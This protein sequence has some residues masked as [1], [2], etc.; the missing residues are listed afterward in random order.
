MTQ[1]EGVTKEEVTQFGAKVSI[2]ICSLNHLNASK[3]PQKML[4]HIC[5]DSLH[6]FSFLS[7]E[8]HE[9]DEK[10]FGVCLVWSHKLALTRGSASEA[11]TSLACL[12]V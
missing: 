11:F 9:Q 3:E 8:S 7:I 4:C 1:E 12:G 2:P 10:S 5:F 6:F